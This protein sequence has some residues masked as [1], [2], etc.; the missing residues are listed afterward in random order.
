M[1]NLF[2]FLIVHL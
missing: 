2:N 1:D